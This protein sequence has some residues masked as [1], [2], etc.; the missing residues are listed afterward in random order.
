V[1]ISVKPTR[2]A[3]GKPAMRIVDSVSSPSGAS[4]A[5]ITSPLPKIDREMTYRRELDKVAEFSTNQE[6]GLW[7]ELHVT[8]GVPIDDKRSIIE[9][10]KQAAYAQVWKL[11]PAAAKRDKTAAGE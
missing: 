3:D 6:I 1:S 9:T 10:A 4:T 7:A 8:V 2:D 5:Y 11:V